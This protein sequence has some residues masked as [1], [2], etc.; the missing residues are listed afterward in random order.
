VVREENK[1]GKA[2]LKRIQNKKINLR[3]FRVVQVVHE[4]IK[5]MYTYDIGQERYRVVG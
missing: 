3:W 5:K 4:A 2:L 1:R